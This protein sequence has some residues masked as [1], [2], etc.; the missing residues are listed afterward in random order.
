ML[1]RRWKCSDKRA[2]KW[3]PTS[4]ASRACVARRC[5]DT[6]RPPTCR[7]RVQLKGYKLCRRRPWKGRYKAM[8]VLSSANYILHLLLFY[9]LA[10]YLPASTRPGGALWR[11]IRYWTCRPLFAHCG[12]NVNIERGAFFGGGKISI[13]SNSGIGINAVIGSGTRIGSDVMMGPEVLI[14]TINHCTSRVDIPMIQQ[15]YRP[16]ASVSIGDDVWIG[17]RVIILPGVTIGSGSVLG[18]GAVISSSVP[19]GSVV[20]GNPGHVVR[21]RDGSSHVAHDRTTNAPAEPFDEANSG[22]ARP[23]ASVRL[24]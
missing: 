13:G 10:R 19:P 1:D 16:L 14:F 12:Q 22:R 23:S 11:R 6:A 7:Q 8:D 2:I 18:A 3:S 15:G 5:R 21:Y 24:P 4:R 17:A 20:V 9:G